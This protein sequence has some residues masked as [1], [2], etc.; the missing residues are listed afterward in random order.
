MANL[1]VF[2]REGHSRK[3]TGECGGFRAQLESVARSAHRGDVRGDGYFAPVELVKDP[4]DHSVRFSSAE[5][6]QLIADDRTAIVRRRTHLPSRMT[7]SIPWCNWR[8]CSRAG[9]TSSPRSEVFLRSVLTDAQKEYSG[10]RTDRRR[11]DRDQ[12][13]EYACH[14]ARGCASWSITRCRFSCKPVPARRGI[15]TRVPRRRAEIVEQA[16][17]VLGR[18][19]LVCKVR[20]RKSP[21]SSTLGCGATSSSHPTSTCRVSRGRQGAARRGHDGGGY[22]DRCNSPPGLQ[23]GRASALGR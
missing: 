4:D 15:S 7:A 23:A 6:E 22:G 11:A 9:P 18:A 12:E 2:E 14:H 19:G 16:S 5:R 21:S 20:S 3:R 8:R 10:E 17:D 13:T 1:D